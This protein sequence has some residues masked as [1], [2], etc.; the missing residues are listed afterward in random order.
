MLN[1]PSMAT[2]GS[3]T[4]RCGFHTSPSRGRRCVLDP[5]GSDRDGHRPRTPTEVKAY[6]AAFPW[7]AGRSVSIGR[8]G[9][10]PC[11]PGLG[12]SSRKPARHRDQQRTALTGISELP[13]YRPSHLPNR[14]PLHDRL[15]EQVPRDADRLGSWLRTSDRRRHSQTDSRT[16][17][18]GHRR[19]AVLPARRTPPTRRSVDRPPGRA[20][21]RFEQVR[22]PAARGPP[23]VH[24][25]DFRCGRWRREKVGPRRGSGCAASR[26]CGC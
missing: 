22:C 10:C 4:T 15:A 23:G 12:P 11:G 8:T 25:D 6:S 26:R 5:R 13:K 24:E 19:M 17:R 16:R 9:T 3:A 14:V 1:A 18:H 2:A 20:T 7:P 21:A